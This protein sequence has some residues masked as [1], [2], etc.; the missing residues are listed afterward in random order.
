MALD[1]LDPRKQSLLSKLNSYIA[2]MSFPNYTTN[3]SK[4]YTIW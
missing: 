3:E 2:N 1:E 4:M